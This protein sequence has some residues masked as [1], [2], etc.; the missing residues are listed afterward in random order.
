MKAVFLVVL[1][2]SAAGTFCAALVGIICLAARKSISACWQYRMLSAALL[3]FLLPIGTAA[4]YLFLPAQ[5]V[6]GQGADS[7]GEAVSESFIYEQPVSGQGADRTAEALRSQRAESEKSSG[8]SQSAAK[9]PGITMADDQMVGPAKIAYQN[10]LKRLGLEK[11]GEVSEKTPDSEEGIAGFIQR[12]SNDLSDIFIAVS[13]I[14]AVGAAIF[15]AYQIFCLLRFRRR[16]KKT[17]FSVEDEETLRVFGECLKSAGYRGKAEKDRSLRTAEIRLLSSNLI[18]TPMITGLFRTYLILPE[19]EMS[20][21]ELKMVFDH[22]LVHFKRKDLWRKAAALLA[23][24]LH[25]FNPAIHLLSSRLDYF[26][27]LSCDEYVV[28]EM[29]K[30][31]RGEY[32]EMILNILERADCETSP[33]YAALTDQKRVMKGRL[34]H[35]MNC[36]KGSKEF[37]RFP[38]FL[39]R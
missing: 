32:G 33:I 21:S 22:E 30:D 37:L 19:I 23:R 10:R 15:A 25:W 14:W 24:S 11:S 35:V 3:I 31:Q 2:M 38:R 13:W 4:G 16:I 29:Q 12:N 1:I 34:S 17:C 8:D 28:R 36:K 9:S 5:P 6:G 20:E 26:C 27:E 18:H 7:K 39:S